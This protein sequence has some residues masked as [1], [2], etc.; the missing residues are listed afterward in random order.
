LARGA[1]DERIARGCAALGIDKE[2]GRIVR[3]LSGG[4]RRKVELVR[5][6]LHQP[7]VLLMDE[8]SVGLDP[9]SRRDLLAAIRADVAARAT[10]VLWATHLV[11]E[12]EQADR[13]LVLHRGKLLA[14]GTP[15][16]V[17]GQ[18][19]GPTLEAGF[20]ASTRNIPKE[21]AFA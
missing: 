18:L 9:A 4:N 3:E 17:N 14:D 20:I 19:G 8:A 6:L 2:R 10:S 16:A 7:A 15:S 12:A 13:V 5:A 1:A 21:T 11:E